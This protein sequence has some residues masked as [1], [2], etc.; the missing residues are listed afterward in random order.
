MKKCPFCGGKSRVSIHEMKYYG[1]NCFGWKK[2]K[3]GAQAICDKCHARG[4]V[5][6]EIIVNKGLPKRLLNFIDL[7]ERAEN[8]WNKRF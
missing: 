3:Y 7:E 2:I 1:Q 5:V 6:T 8:A 4:G